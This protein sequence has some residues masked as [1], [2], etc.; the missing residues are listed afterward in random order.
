VGRYAQTICELSD[1]PEDCNQ[2]EFV[3]TVLRT[4]ARER[5]FTERDGR[6][7]PDDRHVAFLRRFDLDYGARRLRF[8]IAALSWWYEAQ[9][10]GVEAPP[11]EALDQGKAAL[12]GKLAMLTDAMSGRSLGT[13]LTGLVE[14]CFERQRI[15]EWPDTPERYAAD[16]EDDL[17]ALE[18]AL[19]AALDKQLEGFGAKLF[20]SVQEVTAGWS[21]PLRRDLLVRYLG[22]PLWDAILFPVQS[23]ADVGERD[24]VE[25][26]RFSPSEAVAIG[27][28]SADLSGAKLGHFGAFFS[29]E[30]RENDYL[31]GRLDSAER[32][33]GLLLGK[34]PE[35]LSNAAFRAVVDQEQSNLTKVPKLF[36]HLS[37]QLT[38]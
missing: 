19:G 29:R 17:L 4:W 22:F 18:E 3:R 31:W 7:A 2:A 24:A 28:A 25:I 30:G 9:K 12:Y 37:R 21:G 32:L 14:Q 13:D 16:H 33:M 27:A 5:L 36:D 34:P 10:E 8:V 38:L 23:V 26:T 20:E 35:D 1:F 15:D 6:L 11:R